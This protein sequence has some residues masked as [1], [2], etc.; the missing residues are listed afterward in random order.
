MSAQSRD[1]YYPGTEE[2]GADEMRVTSCGTG[3]PAAR[4]SQAATCWLVELGNGDK[5]VF[6]IGSG[7]SA[8]LASLD[9]P[10][11]FLDRVFLTHLHQD[12][13][14]DLVAL[15]IGGWTGG[16][17]GPL[18]VWGP[19]GDKPERGTKHMVESLKSTM[20]W[21]VASRCGII[22]SGGGEIEVEEF[23]Y[24]QVNEVVYENNGVTIRS[25]PAIHA[26]DGCISYGLEWNGLKFVFGG[27]TLPNEWYVKYAKGADI[28]IHECF[29][30]P[31]LMMEKYGFGPAA[32]LNVATQVHTVPAAFG[33]VMS[34]V[35]PRMA[36]AFHFFNDYDTRYDI[37]TGV[38]RT[39][40]GPLTLADD[41]LVWNVT[42]DEIRVREAIVDDA[43]WPTPPPTPPD[44]PD[45]SEKVQFSEFI[46]SGRLD[47]SET[48]APLI[49][50]FKKEHG[51]D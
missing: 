39:Y 34:A 51:L 24:K 47:V 42:K 23:D 48:L 7:S 31:P 28:A 26:M 37:H 19:S 49:D 11:D 8:N 40:D 14:G 13:I 50:P 46:A 32:A 6:D 16:R 9:I 18:H 3:M 38:R 17:H 33:D 41:L 25:W 10:Y 27:D 1:M 21:D 4:R 44:D 36:V 29:M 43:A 22:P 12:H 5:F 20:T 15:W 2:L 45:P 35:R 30:S